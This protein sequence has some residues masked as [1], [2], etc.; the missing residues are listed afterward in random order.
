MSDD[1]D[2]DY[3]DKS[4]TESDN[5]IIDKNKTRKR[6]KN[7]SICKS[8]QRKR[9]LNSG[10]AYISTTGRNVPARQGYDCRCKN[11]CTSKILIKEKASILSKFNDLAD[12]QDS[13]IFGL[14]TVKSVA[15]YVDTYR[16]LIFN[17]LI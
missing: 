11:Q 3:S 1:L 7:K 4:D 8:V 14:I 5:E 17:Y 15:R 10:L 16:Y 2:C 9:N 6:K 13:Y 12:V